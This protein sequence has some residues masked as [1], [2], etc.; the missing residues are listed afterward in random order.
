M[1]DL[2]SVSICFDSLDNKIIFFLHL[3]TLIV[4]PSTQRLKGEMP[5]A[6]ALFSKPICTPKSTIVYGLWK[7]LAC[8]STRIEYLSFEFHL[9][10]CLGRYNVFTYYDQTQLKYSLFFLNLFRGGILSLSKLAFLK[11]LTLVLF[12]LA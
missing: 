11:I 6:L 4:P 12:T 10:F 1:I 3:R 2:F 8:Y 5:W 9:E 7:G